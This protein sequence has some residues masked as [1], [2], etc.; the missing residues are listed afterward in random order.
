MASATACG[1]FT[2]CTTAEVKP[3][4]APP[5][6]PP[7]YVQVPH[8]VGPEISDVRAIFTDRTAMTPDA[9][10]DC[11]A[12]FRKLKSLTQSADELNQ[13]ARELVRQD[14]VKAHWCY[15]GLILKLEDDLKTESYLSE[16]Q[17]K[18]LDTYAYLTPMG[19]AFMQE[20]HDSRY[21]R[22]AVRHYRQLSEWVF[23]R[24]LEASPQATAELVE[25]SNPFGLLREPAA[26]T[27]I[28]EKY[29]LAKPAVASAPV[30]PIG[31][32]PGAA[33]ETVNLPA[34]PEQAPA[35]EQIPATD[36]T[37][38]FEPHPFPDP[39]MMG[40]PERTPAAGTAVPK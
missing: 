1:V 13:G 11:D 25:A 14:P 33:A 21:L 29:N 4:V 37:A 3:Q 15:Y 23:Y 38:S 24:K 40:T 16:R 35:I 36:P 6:L 28:L 27:P 39:V 10:K 18:V 30:A 19:R 31:A 34:M 20:F 17:K 32:S 9:L 22:W 12:D 26:D 2:G 7:A 5:A 8:P